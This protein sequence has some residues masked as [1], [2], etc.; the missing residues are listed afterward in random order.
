MKQNPQNPTST[1]NT[2]QPTRPSLGARTQLR[3]PFAPGERACCCS[4]LPAVRVVLRPEEGRD[5]SVDLLM[6]GHH[7]RRSAATLA[8]RG[9]AIFDSTGKFIL[10]DGRSIATLFALQPH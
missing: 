2:H 6:C 1:A 3:R 5:H 7:Y 4:A 9:A 10:T 8:D